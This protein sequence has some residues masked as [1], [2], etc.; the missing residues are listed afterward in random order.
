MV[1]FKLAG[2]DVAIEQ[3]RRLAAEVEAQRAH[4][5]NPLDER[6]QARREMTF[7]QLFQW[8]LENHARQNKRT[9]KEDQQKFNLHLQG[10]ANRKVSTITR[11]DVAAVHRKIGETSPGSANR[12][13]ALISSVFGRA[14]ALGVDVQNPA[15]GVQRFP[16]HQ[17][18]R[19]L[20]P[21]EMERFMAAVDAEPEPWPD[22]FHIC[23]FTGA[24]RNNVLT[25]RWTE[26]DLNARVWRIPGEKFKNGQPQTVHLPAPAVEILTS[27]QNDKADWVFPS[28]GKLG[29]IRSPRQAW[30]RITERA[31]LSGLWIHDLRRSLGSWMA[32]SGSN[33][34]VIGKTLGH[35]SP[36]ITAR[37]TR[38]TLD[39]VRVG[40]DTAVAAMLAAAKPA[41]K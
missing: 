40:V 15:K 3:A 37:Y 10:L 14:A 28:D 34:S 12:T 6:K 24:R 30:E 13:L 21:D 38:V 22:F 31:G 29:H 5:I 17:R 39:P 16:E 25:M 9:W 11:Q 27:R 18:E 36:S 33:Q 41:K 1:R 26:I 20:L 2:G 8:Y 7:T 35:L 19:F 32:G 4:G 23:L